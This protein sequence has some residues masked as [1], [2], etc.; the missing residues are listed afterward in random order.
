M[1]IPD[2]AMVETVAA[3]ELPPDPTAPGLARGFVARA[4]PA[5]EQEELQEIAQLLVSELVT[6]AVVHA[7]SAV[8][9]EVAVDD[10]G[11]TVRVRDADTGPLVMRAGGGSELDEGGRGF[12][13]VD[14]LADSWGTEHRGGRKVVW[15]RVSADAAAEEAAAPG[16]AAPL[17]EPPA[18]T[19]GRGR[20]STSE[21]RLRTL[22]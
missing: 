13:L 12:V 17:P 1:D 14:R 3:L 11:L 15:F 16:T 5:P 19:A 10:T 7:A 4:L 8:E 22:L 2:T 9:V 20:T 18:D 6:N 21:Q